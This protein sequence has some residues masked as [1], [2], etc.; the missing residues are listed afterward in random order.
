VEQKR[1]WELK[2]AAEPNVLEMY[3]YGDVKPNGYDWWTDQV[4]ESETSAEHF[5]QELAKY[6]G[7]HEIRLYVNSFGGSVLKLW[8]FETN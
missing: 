3:I 5:R 2:Q 7:V 8:P 4:I 1:I 6:P